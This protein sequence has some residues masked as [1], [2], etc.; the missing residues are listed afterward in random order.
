MTSLYDEHHKY[1]P[2]A[3]ALDTSVSNAL[4]PIFKHYTE[5]LGYSPREVSQIMQSAAYE[6]ALNEL[7]YQDMMRKRGSNV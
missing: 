5:T 3:Q 6:I 1:T 4:E 2:D 7:R